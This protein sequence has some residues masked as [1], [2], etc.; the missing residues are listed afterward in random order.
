[1][2]VVYLRKKGYRREEVAELLRIDEDTVTKH[3]EVRRKRFTGLIGGK[4]SPAKKPI[5]AVYTLNGQFIGF[6]SKD[7]HLSS[8][9]YAC[10]SISPP[11]FHRSFRAS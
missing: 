3:E 5:G 9:G 11:A 1:M 4:L 8:A 2:L 7:T 10:I 6:I